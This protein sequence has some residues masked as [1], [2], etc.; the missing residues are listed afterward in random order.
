M[1][2]NKSFNIFL[3]AIGVSSFIQYLFS[4]KGACRSSLILNVLRV[5]TNGMPNES[6]CGYY[7]HADIFIYQLHCCIGFYLQ[8]ITSFRAQYTYNLYYL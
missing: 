4:Q 1:I 8:F 6:F 3:A 5:L 2:V 7:P